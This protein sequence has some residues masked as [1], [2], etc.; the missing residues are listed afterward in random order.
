MALPISLLS[1]CWICISSL[2]SNGVSGCVILDIHAAMLSM[3]WI[4]GEGGVHEHC[5]VDFVHCQVAVD[6]FQSIRGI[7][8]CGD[9]FVIDVCRFDRVYLLL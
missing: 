7:L 3:D 5:L 9:G 4:W 2:W 8:H 6:Y 1:S